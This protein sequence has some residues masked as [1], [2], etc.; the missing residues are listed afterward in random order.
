MT[1]KGQTFMLSSSSASVAVGKS[2]RLIRLILAIG[3][4]SSAATGAAYPQVRKLTF[5]D[6]VRAQ[7]AIERVYYSHQ[8]G[9]KEPFEEAVARTYLE[10]KVRKYLKQSAALEEFWK[11]PAT[12]EMLERELDRM[13]VGTRLPDR[14][15][16]LYTALGNDPFLIKECLA[17]QILVERLSRSFFA[18]D[19]PIHEQARQRSER[20]RRRLLAHELDP[21]SEYPDRSVV[22]IA[23]RE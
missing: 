11:T 7:E 9:A 15:L 16:E 19:A 17:R 6:R 18:F 13:A 1:G 8:I 23:V 10:A 14:L 22:Q 4:V 12:D 20:I 21:F 2:T 3:F 5:E